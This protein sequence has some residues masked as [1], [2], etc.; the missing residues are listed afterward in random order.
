V[1]DSVDW[2]LFSVG[3]SQKPHFITDDADQ[4]ITANEILVVAREN[5]AGCANFG[6]P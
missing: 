4:T 1:S 3:Y 6:T 5:A 2:G